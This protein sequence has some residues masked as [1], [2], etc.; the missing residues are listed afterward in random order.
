MSY[1]RG[2]REGR[3]LRL[4]QHV[5]GMET[6]GRALRLSDG[7]LGSI[8]LLQQGVHS[9]SMARVPMTCP[10]VKEACGPAN[11]FGLG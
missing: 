1:V 3:L 4:G 8:V 7:V 10:D 11:G 6:G 5:R 2:L 9:I